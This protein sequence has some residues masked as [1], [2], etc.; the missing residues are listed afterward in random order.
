MF[1]QMNAVAFSLVF[2]ICAASTGGVMAQM[3]ENIYLP[4]ILPGDEQVLTELLKQRRSVRNFKNASLSMEELS[5]LLWAA[6]GITHPHGYRTAPSAGA[7]YPL[8]LYVVVGQVEGLDQGVY[9]YLAKKHQL[10]KTL[11]GD[12]RKR[13]A[14]EA[15]WQSW[16][17]D[18]SVV[19]IFTAVYKRTTRK[20]GS[21]GKRYVHIEVG[22]AGQNLFL[23]AISLGLSSAV[24]GA[25]SDKNVKDLLE[26]PDNAE[27]VI[28]MPVGKNANR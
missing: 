18:A 9:H 3:Q 12:K 14:S 5:M 20:Y 17:S 4:K 1:Q 28:M 15:Y 24:V 26:I 10:V 6:Q 27:P 22:H 23:Q 8:E 7:L 25:F 19:V 21:R 11:D 13:L 16:M 2:L